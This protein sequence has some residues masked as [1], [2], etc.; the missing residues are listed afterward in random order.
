MRSFSER[1]RREGERG[2]R[3]EA[4][5]AGGSEN[6]MRGGERERQK[7]AK[8]GGS[9]RNCGAKKTHDSISRRSAGEEKKG[10]RGVLLLQ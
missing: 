3:T 2:R 5:E 4:G 8:M 10:E 6:V 1:R 9:V 7:R